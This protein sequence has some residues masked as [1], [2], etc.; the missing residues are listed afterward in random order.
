MENKQEILTEVE[1]TNILICEFM[2]GKYN[3]IFD[4]EIN[5][6]SDYIGT[7]KY[8]NSWDALMP[9]VEKISKAVDSLENEQVNLDGFVCKSVIDDE[10][11]YGVIEPV[12]KAI[13]AF[14][15]WHNSTQQH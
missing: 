6:I 4:V 7:L 15:H 1:Q 11:T 13:V 14:I 12:Y 3:G 8:H 5:G 9:V 10:L 2:G